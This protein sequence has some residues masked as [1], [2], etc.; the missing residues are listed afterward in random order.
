VASPVATSYL[1]TGLANDTTYYYVVSGVNATGESANSTE[2]SATPFGP[3][4]ILSVSPASSGQ[5]NLQFAGT[6]GQNYVIET[7]S[8]LVSWAPV[9]TNT[10][11]GGVFTFTDANATNSA[12]F[13][14]ARQ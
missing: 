8:D 7:S 10:P 9:Y 12:R 1:N 11:S 5:F 14:R 6:D 2:V 4:I 13:Y 3:P